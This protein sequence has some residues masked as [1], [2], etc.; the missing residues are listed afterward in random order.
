MHTRTQS[1]IKWNTY[2][3]AYHKDTDL[4]T[5]DLV[6]GIHITKII[7]QYVKLMKKIYLSEVKSP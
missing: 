1:L 4:N 7:I 6:H 3:D 5:S 2:T